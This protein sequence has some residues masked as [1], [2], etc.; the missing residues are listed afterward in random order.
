MAGVGR[1]GGQG[2]QVVAQHLGGEIL[3]HRVLR[4]PR[5]MLEVQAVLEALERFFYS[6]AL[7]NV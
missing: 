7:N 3:Y 6:P 2:L 1:Q 5:N 4:Q